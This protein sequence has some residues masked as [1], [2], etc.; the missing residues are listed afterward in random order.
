MEEYTAVN[1]PEPADVQVVEVPYYWQAVPQADD[2]YSIQWT[3][4]AGTVI[5]SQSVKI[6]GEA[7]Q[8]QK[9]LSFVAND[10]R[11]VNMGLFGAADVSPLSLGTENST[12]YEVVFYKMKENANG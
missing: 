8:V 12:V 11:L 1:E 5:C 4:E 6:V 3:N 10:L 9:A 7:A 2:T